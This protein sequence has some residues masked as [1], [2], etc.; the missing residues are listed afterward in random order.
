MTWICLVTIVGLGSISWPCKLMDSIPA[1]QTV[2]LAW[3][4]CLVCHLYINDVD[5]ARNVWRSNARNPTGPTICNIYVHMVAWQLDEQEPQP[6]YPQEYWC[7]STTRPLRSAFQV[8]SKPCT[9]TQEG[10]SNGLLHATH[11]RGSGPKV[12]CWLPCKCVMK[13]REMLPVLTWMHNANIMSNCELVSTRATTI[14]SFRTVWC[15]V[16]SPQSKIHL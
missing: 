16:P 4:C 12:R 7:P 15:C 1:N 2:N 9:S 10:Q 6:F 14:A 13:I 3:G 5:V 8:Q 11:V